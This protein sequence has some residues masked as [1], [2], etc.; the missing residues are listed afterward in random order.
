MDTKVKVIEVNKVTEIKTV[1]NEA[2][3]IEENQI[4][5][6]FERS[7]KMR[8][9][10]VKPKKRNEKQ[11]EQSNTKVLNKAVLD[12]Y[13]KLPS[14]FVFL[15]RYQG[16]KN[17]VGQTF[18]PSIAYANMN[19]N[20]ILYSLINEEKIQLSAVQSSLLIFDAKENTELD[21]VKGQK[22]Y[23]LLSEY[24]KKYVSEGV[25]NNEVLTLFNSL[26]EIVGL[27]ISQARSGKTKGQ[28]LIKD[29]VLEFIN[30]FN[31]TFITKVDYLAEQLDA[32]KTKK[33]IIE[34]EKI[35]FKAWKAEQSEAE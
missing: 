16:F 10:K 27:P 28:I 12:E 7:V 30:T 3:I 24:F 18:K 2:I 25:T 35:A 15:K 14:A 6:S 17:I 26:V 5:A 1:K 20:D 11:T 8:K 21:V 29:S 22:I 23:G 4:I 32:I 13:K 9:N 31:P 34:A 33:A 19:L